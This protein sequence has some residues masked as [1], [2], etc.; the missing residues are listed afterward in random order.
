MT[1]GHLTQYCSINHSVLQYQSR[2]AK[3]DWLNDQDSH[4][5]AREHEAESLGQR[6]LTLASSQLQ[7][8][9]SG[10]PLAAPSVWA[11][12][13]WWAVRHSCG[14]FPAACAISMH[15]SHVDYPDA[16]RS[17]KSLQRASCAAVPDPSL[18][19]IFPGLS[20]I[21]SISLDYRKTSTRDS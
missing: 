5:A 4:A 21:N 17:K 11:S 14:R 15:A 1:V 12:Y 3:P 6:V 16:F 7:A 2:N 19:R 13:N 20:L 18:L 8:G 9:S 10:A